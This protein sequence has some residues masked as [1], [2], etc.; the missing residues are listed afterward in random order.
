MEVSAKDLRTKTKRLLDSVDRGEEV[1]LTYRGKA[2]AR[3]L[4]LEDGGPPAAEKQ[5]LFGIWRDRDDLRDVERHVDRLRE[6]RA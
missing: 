3:V 2:R 5:E 4:A 6:A 1:I